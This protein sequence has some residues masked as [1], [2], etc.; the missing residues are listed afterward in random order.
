MVSTLRAPPPSRQGRHGPAPNGRWETLDNSSH[1]WGGFGVPGA[2]RWVGRVS[3]ERPKRSCRFVCV[4]VCVILAQGPSLSG[5]SA[6]TLP[7]I[8][9]HDD[10]LQS[11]SLAMHG[12]AAS[13]EELP[14]H[15]CVGCHNKC[16]APWKCC[17]G[18]ALACGV[19]ARE[20]GKAPE[21]RPAGWGRLGGHD[22][23]GG[24]RHRQNSGHDERPHPPQKT[25]SSPTK[26]K[27]THPRRASK[28][29]PP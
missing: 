17:D 16:A 19:C 24:G 12:L 11:A 8:T 25:S 14:P 2:T 15:K 9:S 6:S 13:A 28:S 10:G 22:L 27:Q 4:C 7:R 18:H 29:G 21:T 20:D 26:T 3:A 1:W 23:G 5:P